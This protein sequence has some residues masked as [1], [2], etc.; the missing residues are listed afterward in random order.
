[1]KVQ[2]FA[3]DSYQIGYQMGCAA[4]DSLKSS[5][6]KI[7]GIAEKLCSIDLSEIEVN[8][9][10]WLEKLPEQFQIEA[11]G[12]SEG[13]DCPMD[14]I[15]K[16]MFFDK[17]LSGGC[18]SFI[19]MNNENAWVGRN[20][21]Y[22]APQMWSSVSVISKNDMIPV[23]LFGIGGDLFSGTGYNKEQIW[24]HYN[25]L[26]VWDVPAQEACPPYVF[27]RMA[28]ESCRNMNDVEQMLKHI[29]RDGGM[30]L[31]FVDGKDNTCAIYECTCNS[32][33]KR[34]ITSQ[35]V[36]GANHYNATAVPIGF[37]HNFSG[38]VKREKAAEAILADVANDGF[39]LKSL[40]NVLAH[41]NVEQNKGLSGT[42]YANIACP[43]TGELYYACDGFPAASKS[44]WERINWHW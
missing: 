6:S 8:P 12:L 4:K 7:M 5:I 3:G 33:K 25:W 1:M 30:N 17:F 27:L 22:I 42:V 16:W 19:V 38:S 15:A 29:P 40:I 23:M 35:Y 39:S 34:E 32:F 2:N 13:S 10:S 24:L 9:Y 41:P 21:D 18:T 26:P 37:N 31:F 28:L 43:A 11:R 36:V 14:E 20:N 44:C